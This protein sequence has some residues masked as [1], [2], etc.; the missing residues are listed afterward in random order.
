MVALDSAR[1]NIQISYIIP[2]QYIC[3]FL[4]IAGETVFISLYSI[5][6]LVFVTETKCVYW[7]VRTECLGA[8]QVKVYLEKFVFHSLYLFC[9]TIFFSFAW[10]IR[11]F[12]NDT[13]YQNLVTD[14]FKNA[15]LFKAYAQ[16]LSNRRLVPQYFD[17][18]LHNIKRDNIAKWLYYILIPPI[19]VDNL[20]RSY[21]TG[22][23]VAVRTFL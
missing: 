16:R 4:Q 15:G 1:F 8:V 5:D 9:S 20:I 23:Q 19:E 22:G 11:S 3:G 18:N 6:C 17:A 12:L 7:A 10:A 13:K 14:F 2:V 21:L